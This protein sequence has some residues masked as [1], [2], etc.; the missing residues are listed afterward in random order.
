M[1]IR[2]INSI[3]INRS[4]NNVDVN[5]VWVRFGYC[6]CWFHILLSMIWIN[7]FFLEVSIVCYNTSLRIYYVIEVKIVSL[8]IFKQIGSL[9]EMTRFR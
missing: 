8:E 3:I 1:A 9:M 4:C 5:D 7:I 2:L 6:C